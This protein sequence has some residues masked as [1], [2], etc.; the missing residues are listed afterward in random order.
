L[1]PSIAEPLCIIAGCAVA[2]EA[3]LVSLPDGLGSNPV[4]IRQ[5]QSH[6]AVAFPTVGSDLNLD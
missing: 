5:A 1:L 4:R 3:K 2:P 6:V